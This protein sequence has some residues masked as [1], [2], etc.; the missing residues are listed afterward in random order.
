MEG[1]VGHS[2]VAGKTY[3]QGM[4]F[5]SSIPAYE[6]KRLT[7][8]LRRRKE[9]C[10]LVWVYSFTLPNVPDYNISPPTLTL[11][12]CVCVCVCVYVCLH[13]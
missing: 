5:L 10:P 12:M 9:L 13:D 11:S 1:G 2:R 8:V 4:C 3:R 7:T 6:V